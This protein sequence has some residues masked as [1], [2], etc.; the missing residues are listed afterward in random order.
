MDPR[1]GIS[2]M[3]DDYFIYLFR[4]KH[5]P[6]PVGTEEY[7]KQEYNSLVIEAGKYT[8]QDSI[9]SNY[10]LFGKRGKITPRDEPSFR[11]TYSFEGDSAAAYI[12]NKDGEFRGKP[13]YLKRLK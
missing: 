5:E 8:V 12:L 6:L 1:E 10:M 13:M 7:Y 3:Y 4:F 2:V 11:W 9:A